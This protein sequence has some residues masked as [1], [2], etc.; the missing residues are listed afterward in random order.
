[1]QVYPGAN[2]YADQND[3]II[4]IPRRSNRIRNV[5][6]RD[7]CITGYWWESEDSL[8]VYA[9][10]SQKEPRAIQDALLSPVKDK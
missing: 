6:N 7:G 2:E 8:H 1:M 9:D 4:C 5:P 3:E 10:E